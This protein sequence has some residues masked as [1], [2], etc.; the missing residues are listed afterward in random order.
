MSR[1]RRRVCLDG[2]LKLDL[3][4]LRHRGFV[5]PG[6]RTRPHPI[7]WT[8][9]YW[10][11]IASGLISANM[12]GSYEG[13]LRIQLGEL[14]QW[15]TLVPQ[16]RHFGGRQWYLLRLPRDEPTCVC[17]VEASW[18]YSFLQSSGLGSPS[19]LRIPISRSR[20][21][22]SSRPS[23]DQIALDCRS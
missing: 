15:I 19:R 8:S 3:N 2:G 10:G 12:E 13:W 11:E 14:D 1:P 6:S 7:C 21:S 23:Q 16:C 18:C 9:D 5:Q 17:L 22:R 20:Q 4:K